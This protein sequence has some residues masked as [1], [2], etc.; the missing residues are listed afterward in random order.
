[1]EHF[2]FFSSNASP[3]QNVL[4][5]SAYL[6]FTHFHQCL[7]AGNNTLLGQI[8]GDN[9]TQGILLASHTTQAGTQEG[10]W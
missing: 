3:P 8:E 10:T 5:Y 1:M 2:V 6:N 9:R 7:R 4:C